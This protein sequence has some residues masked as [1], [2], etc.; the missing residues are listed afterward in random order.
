MDNLILIVIVFILII[1]G[2]I[3]RSRGLV[4]M[5]LSI[6]AMILS[7]LI[8]GVLTPPICEVLKNKLGLIDDMEQVVAEA[9][10]D[11]HIEDIEYVNEL[12]FNNKKSKKLWRQITP[13]ITLL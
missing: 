1:C 7:I 5:V 6:A 10:A 3:G 2:L 9:F 12:E 4:K 13:I 8:S 11:V